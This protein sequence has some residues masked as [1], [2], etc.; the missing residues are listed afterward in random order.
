MCTMS[1]W[2]RLIAHLVLASALLAAVGCVDTEAP[3][4]PRWTSTHFL[5]YAEP[6]D[7]DPCEAIMD[8]LEHHFAVMQAFFRFDWSAGAT[9]RYDKYR[10]QASFEADA[11]CG[12]TAAA[13][14]SYGTV[15]STI[16]F[17]QHELIHA[18]LTPGG[19][20]P[21][22]LEEGVAVVLTWQNMICDSISDPTPPELSWADAVR[23]VDPAVDTRVYLA[24]ARL[25]G[26]LLRR[27]DPALFMRL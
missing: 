18:Y 12:A 5:Y 21:V 16:A 1:G 15:K 7:P 4:T 23:V 2:G 8:R 9:I 3:P 17:D 11:N 25:V 14:E 24:G 27:Y 13:C 10:D 6:D 19:R 20:A 26:H 22:L